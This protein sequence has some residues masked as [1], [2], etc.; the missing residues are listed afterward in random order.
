MKAG[1]AGGHAF[2]LRYALPTGVA[3]DASLEL[4][5]ED[6]IVAAR[7]AVHLV[8]DGDWRTVSAATKGAVNAGNYRLRLTLADGAN[9][10]V[11]S[12]G[13]D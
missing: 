4:V 10:M 6:G 12:V 8:G 2:A 11:D 13:I 1:L 3:R 7:M 9:L 5:G